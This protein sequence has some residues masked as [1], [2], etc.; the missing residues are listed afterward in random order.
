MKE[1]EAWISEKTIP[2]RLKA[3]FQHIQDYIIGALTIAL[4][5]LI[6]WGVQE[7]PP[8][9]FDP[10]GSAAVPKAIAFILILLASGLLARRYFEQKS[11][12]KRAEYTK[13]YKE[14]PWLATAVVGLSIL[15]TLALETG[16]LGFRWGT[17]AYIFL[18]SDVLARK[19]RKI[20]GISLGLALLIGI[21]GDYLF[22]NFFFIDLP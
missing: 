6:L 16:L 18:T 1:Q 15:Y 19:N 5:G 14:E 21:L 11:A 7:V 22:A 20:M 2:G 4:A 13:P 10:L 9:F 12:S 17:V 8:P 3:Y